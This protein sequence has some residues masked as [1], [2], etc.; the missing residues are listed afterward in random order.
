MPSDW[1]IWA[2][3]ILASALS[4]AVAVSLGIVGVAKVRHALSAGEADAL[5]SPCRRSA[6]GRPLPPG[7]G[8]WLAN[9]LS[10]SLA[11]DE[12]AG[13]YAQATMRWATETRRWD[14]ETLAELDEMFV[15]GS[16]S[17]QRF[18]PTATESVDRLRSLT[19][20]LRE[21]VSSVQWER[22]RRWERLSARGGMT[23][24]SPGHQQMMEGRAVLAEMEAVLAEGDALE[25][26]LGH[27]ADQV[28]E[29]RRRMAGRESS[30]LAEEVERLAG[31][32]SRYA[33]D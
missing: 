3:T 9:P 7:D 22:H 20:D 8:S 21:L 23:D 16:L 33:E 27:L 4:G 6:S 14:G 1:W 17:W 18:V 2:V 11:H 32:I 24:G 28:A 26:A 25:E 29:T 31:D 13:P 15:P 10:S 5:P 30:S 12:T 19:S